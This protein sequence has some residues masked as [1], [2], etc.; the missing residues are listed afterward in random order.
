MERSIRIGKDFNVRWSINKVVDGER[1]PY[2]LAGKELVL[3]YRTPYG[4][5]EATE[6]KTEGNTIVWTF[7]GREQKSLGSYELIL[8]ENGGK[9]GMVTVDTCRAFKLVAHS[10]EE[11]DGSGGDIVI[12]DVV[13]ESEVAFAALRGPQG[14]R[15]PEGPQGPQ[16]PQGERGPQGEQG[17]AGPSYNDTEIKAKL[18]ELSEEIEGLGKYEEDVP[19]YIR[20]VV[21]KDDK[22]L[23]GIKTDGSIEWAEGVP[24][25]IKKF[26]LDELQRVANG[27]VD[28]EDGKQLSTNDFSH[29]DKE[30]LSLLTNYD[31]TRVLNEIAELNK[32]KVEKREGYTLINEVVANTILFEDS[33]EFIHAEIDKENNLIS[34]TRK[35]GKK[36]FPLISTDE[37]DVS[38]SMK[39][40][41]ISLAGLLKQLDMPK[42]IKEELS[43]KGLDFPTNNFESEIAVFDAVKITEP[44]V[45]YD[46]VCALIRIATQEQFDNVQSLINYEIGQ[47]KTN[48]IV[49]LEKDGIL[50]FN[51]KH[52][53]LTK[54][55]YPNASNVRLTIIAS[56]ACKVIGKGVDYDVANCTA[57]ENGMAMFVTDEVFSENL[58][59]VDSKGDELLSE[60]EIRLADSEVELVEPS[61]FLFRIKL[62]QRDKDTTAT[63][64]FFTSWYRIFFYEIDRVENGYAYFY[65]NDATEDTTY[66]W[67]V[68]Q[69]ISYGKVFPRYKLMNIDSGA[70]LLKNGKLYCDIS[71]NNL[72]IC[73]STQF[74]IAEGTT[75]KSLLLKNISF[76][77]NSV[78]EYPN[79]LV[80]FRGCNMDFAAI[81]NCF[82]SNIKTRCVN[83]IDG[84]HNVVMSDC[85]AI[86]CY[87][88]LIYSS[89]DTEKIVVKECYV[90]SSNRNSV[91]YS[92]IE[93]TGKESLIAD[94]E[95]HN[96]PYV[97]IRSGVWVENTEQKYSEVVIER[98]KIWNDGNYVSESWKHGLMDGGAIYVGKHCQRVIVRDNVVLNTSGRKDNR[99][100]F[101]DGYGY[102]ISLYRNI[103]VNT[104][105]CWDVEIYTGPLKA[106][107]NT[108]NFMA[109]NIMTSAYRFQELKEDSSCK[110]G[111]NLMVVTSECLPPTIEVNVKQRDEDYIIK[112]A[113]VNE[114][115]VRIPKE[116]IIPMKN[117]KLNPFVK[118]YLSYKN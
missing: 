106:P 27:K 63:K 77:G 21:D 97:A 3:R 54:E 114:M 17:P 47:G 48:V 80:D 72:H 41:S 35:D 73:K 96:N 6:W 38:K 10:C 102:N 83:C 56:K 7:R 88:R 84:T 115:S 5:K 85:K 1:Q 44:V 59:Y 39:L 49:S 58:L 30:K 26:V 31:D 2:E 74:I 33:E 64:I 105:N 76:L 103:V 20:V 9:D 92:G 78:G 32:T 62:A 61:S 66:G 25:P 116:Y 14:E 99:G 100:I 42:Q 46:G 37:L 70:F 101:V 4:L 94:N 36:Y 23:F 93:L 71:I 18:T 19:S 67:S 104:Q 117:I 86:D 68:N 53:H 45:E 60:T 11:T 24:T 13:L 75:F 65:A 43:L 28:K 89:H 52:F 51:D 8:T 34:A 81:D 98:N 113:E 107:Y 12:E 29:S 15:G 118:S 40:S 110:K 87:E 69:D 109:L 108:N 50:Y 95:L 79:S 22:F 16:G 111:P 112:K 57:F 55:Q 90:D 91:R 82:F